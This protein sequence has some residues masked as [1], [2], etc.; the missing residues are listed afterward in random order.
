MIHAARESQSVRFSV[1][2][3]AHNTADYL[4][5]A[6]DSVTAQTFKD[7]ELIVVCD[8]CSDGAEEI[9]RQR[10]T[11]PILID[12]GNAGA[13]RNAGL[14][15]AKGEYILFLDSDDEYF[16][17]RAFAMLDSALRKHAVDALHFGFMCGEKY[18]SVKGNNGRYWWNVWS[19]AWRREMIGDERF[20][21]DMENTEDL[22]FC[23][24]VFGRPGITH[25]ALEAPLVQYTYPREGSL[26]W[27]AEHGNLK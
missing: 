8:A 17:T 25:A 4:G 22:D 19:R 21:E 16:T 23:R 14:D 9:A 5:R 1:I 10:G 12:R 18:L 3:P 26:S 15:S 24:R 13:A 11:D 27:Q 20:R 6:I 7:Y 2:I